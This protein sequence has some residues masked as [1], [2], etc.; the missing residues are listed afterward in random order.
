MIPDFTVFHLSSWVLVS[1]NRD[2]RGKHC[3]SFFTSAERNSFSMLIKAKLIRR[4]CSIDH[5]IHVFI[6][7]NF[8]NDLSQLAIENP[9]VSSNLYAI[10]KVGKT[11]LPNCIKHSRAYL[12][13]EGATFFPARRSITKSK[14]IIYLV[15]VQY[16]AN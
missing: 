7:F 13:L 15:F 1:I 10:H 4:S 14:V 6:N 3:T 9:M 2:K 12:R 11:S 5:L 8:K 16:I